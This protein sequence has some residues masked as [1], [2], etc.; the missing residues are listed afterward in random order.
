[1]RRRPGVNEALPDLTEPP[2][3][4]FFAFMIRV[5]KP[6]LF[7]FICL[8]FVS[9]GKG[10]YKGPDALTPEEL[11]A[12]IRTA[13]AEAPE[14]LK[15]MS[16]QAIGAFETEEY[17]KALVTFQNI[18]KVPDLSEDQR[19]LA[20]RCLITINEKLRAAVEAGDTTASQFREFNAATK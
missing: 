17:P 20:S 19:A 3:N 12:A 11:P 5:I 9:C 16:E 10:K 7:V 2:L 14:G 6:F 15:A 8:L 4:T 13:Y 18:L 1:M